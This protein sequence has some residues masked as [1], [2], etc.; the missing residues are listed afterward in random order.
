MKQFIKRLFRKL[1]YEVVN[2]QDYRILSLNDEMYQCLEGIKNR[3]VNCHS[4]LDVGA[5][6]TLWSQKAQ[7]VY[8][9]ATFFL[10]EP[11]VEM[12]E[13]LEKFCLSNPGSKYFLAGAGAQ[14]DKL[15]LTVWD[16]LQGSSLLV[17]A[18]E[19]NKLKIKQ[20]EIPILTIDS[21]IESNQITIPDII[22]LDIQGFELEALKGASLTFGHTEV[23]ILEVSLFEILPNTPSFSDIILFMQNRGYV[24]YDFPGYLHRP[25]D[26][27]LGQIDV[28]FVRESGPLRKSNQ[29]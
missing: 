15:L 13:E 29:W 9:N 24:V 20:R 14:S 2:S 21:L 25:Y 6:S 7:R 12:K 17:Q 16:D 18:S 1:G 28:C 4:I 26:G 23:Y 10:I 22:K 27:A 5:N 8:P 11:Q 3:G 19:D